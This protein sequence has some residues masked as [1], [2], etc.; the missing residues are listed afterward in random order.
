M[1]KATMTLTVLALA[2][3]GAQQ[4]RRWPVLPLKE[5]AAILEYTATAGEAVVRVEAESEEELDG[6]QVHDPEGGLILELQ[7]GR[8]KDRGLSGFVVETRESSLEELF[9]TYP[10]GA[11]DLLAS[12]VQGRPARGRA[13]L[14]HALPAA[15]RVIY[16]YEG[17][18]KVPSSRL[19]VRWVPDA[20]AVRYQVST[21][22]D[23]NDGLTVELPG[24]SS[25]FL[26]PDK[27]LRP[28]TRTQLEIAAIA[29][30]GNR[31]LVEVN[32]TTE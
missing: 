31:T 27:I 22:Q 2:A 28:G 7:A 26:V 5:E 19:L 18:V 15:P 10:E 32:F 21:E 11:Y 12:T 30:N 16:P 4:E 1:L 6:V 25:S 23:E 20:G 17:A 3:L 29:R 8:G 9:E 13:V 14:S 24:G